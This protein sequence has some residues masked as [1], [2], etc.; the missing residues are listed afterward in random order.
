MAR[1]KP[2]RIPQLEAPVPAAASRRFDVHIGL[3]QADYERL[4][5]LAAREHRPVANLVKHVLL[6]WMTQ[7]LG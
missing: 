4:E 2:L 6:Q 7:E 1:T 3:D 5:G